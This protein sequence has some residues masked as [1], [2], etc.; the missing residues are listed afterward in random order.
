MAHFAPRVRHDDEEETVTRPL[1]RPA[2]WMVPRPRLQTDLS[3]DLE[4]ITEPRGSLPDFSDDEWI[5]TN[6]L[7]R[8]PSSF[9]TTITLPRHAPQRMADRPLP[10]V[11]RVSLPPRAPLPRRAPSRPALPPVPAFTRPIVIE[12][13]PVPLQRPR[14]PAAPVRV[15]T[16]PAAP[17]SHVIRIP[18]PVRTRDSL[19][20]IEVREDLRVD[21]AQMDV[22][23]TSPIASESPYRPRQETLRGIEAAPQPAP[24]APEPPPAPPTVVIDP[25]AERISHVELRAPVSEVPAFAVPA[26]PYPV[27]RRQRSLAELWRSAKGDAWTAF[28]MLPIAVS[29]V[30]IVVLTLT[31]FASSPGSAAG[32]ANRRVVTATDPSGAEITTGTAFVDGVAK[33]QSLP[34]ALD[35][36]EGQHW[37][38]VAAPGFDAPG[39]RAIAIG[40]AGPEQID[41]VLSPSRPVAAP[42]AEEPPIAAAALPPIEPSPS[43]DPAPAPRSAPPRNAGPT[44]LAA[45]PTVIR[46]I[47]RVGGPARLNINSVPASNVVLDGRPLGRTPKLGVPVEPGAHTV[48]FVNGKKRV[49]QSAVV[50]PGKTAVIAARL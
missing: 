20:E 23:V 5:S 31:A 50:A 18:D 9:D 12:N 29:V 44:P 1:L 3:I 43:P 34:C 17:A 36:P 41:F 30:S 22:L 39:A 38:T 27:P 49:V 4:P 7:P 24:R 21:W 46:P 11:K 19:A 25:R 10:L 15:P 37:I 32:S 42:R 14:V 33:C 47:A 48:V 40:E 45:E 13:A 2:R 28:L 6:E 16:P 26:M 8:P 35:L